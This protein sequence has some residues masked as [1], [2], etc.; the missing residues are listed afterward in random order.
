M[1]QQ[2]LFNHELNTYYY[3]E[4][5]NKELELECSRIVNR[6][7]SGYN[8]YNK[9]RSRYFNTYTYLIRLEYNCKNLLKDK[10]IIVGY[11]SHIS[12]VNSDI[13]NKIISQINSSYFVIKITDKIVLELKQ[14]IL[15]TINKEL[16]QL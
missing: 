3:L 14:D 6:F 7:I 1:Y 16:S 2:S 5:K 9:N 4:T 15:D 13:C 11:K 8:A 10:N 12:D